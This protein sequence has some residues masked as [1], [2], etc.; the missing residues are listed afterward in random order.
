M[1]G[2]VTSPTCALYCVYDENYWLPYSVQSIYEAVPKI[3]V[4]LSTAPW[5]GPERDNAATRASIAALPDPERK[6]EVI[7]GTWSKET[8][9]RNFS[10][11]VAQ[12]AGFAYGFIIDADEIYDV[13]QLRGALNHIAQHPQVESWHIRWFTYWK[14]ARYRIDP[15]EPYDPV[16]FIKLGSCGFIETRNPAATHHAL[17]PPSIAMCH[18]MSYALPDDRLQRKHIAFAGH[19]QSAH[20]RWMTEVWRRWDSD[21]S[22]TNLHPNNPPQYGRAVEQPIELLPAILRPIYERGGLP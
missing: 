2:S 8:E 17:I 7:E 1:T 19:S 18:H 10:L 5:Y 14:S 12:I 3:Y 13:N 21:R 9:Q 11:A 15:I 6:I 4:F 16:A 22:L 20:D